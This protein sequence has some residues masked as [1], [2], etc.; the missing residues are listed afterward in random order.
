[1]Q[2]D[3]IYKIVPAH[4][5]RIA[6][7]AGQFTGSPVDIRDGFIHFS[8]AAQVRETAARHFGGVEDLL[9][10]TV[11]TATLDLLWEPSRGGDLF[12]HLY[13][14]LPVTAV[15]SSERLPLGPDGAHLFP[16]SV[17]R[18]A[19]VGG[20]NGYGQ[21]IGASLPGWVAPPI[22]TRDDFVGH[23]C[24]VSP[25]SPADTD[26]LFDAFALDA[27]DREWTYLPYGPFVDRATLA[28]WVEE[29]SVADDPLLFTVRSGETRIPT[30][31]AGYL[32][33]MPASGSIEVGHLRFSR[34]LRR[35][36]AATEA[37]YLMMRRAFDLGYRRYEWKCDVFNEPSRAAALR[38]GFSFEGI[39]RQATVYKGRTRDTAWYSVIDSEWPALRDVFETWLSPAN[40][41][42]EGRQQTRLSQLMSARTR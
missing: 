37:M 11:S 20:L 5:W 8:T 28:A 23:F 22:P 42:G 17:L 1:M 32:R 41:D 26:A 6:E 13:G 18:G 33:I 15:V 31:V 36:P 38:L 16:A 39:F 24:D 30:G 10:V 19:P 4:L 14:P 29:R 12:P 2:S 35:T 34:L 40:F 7:E 25:V 21:R 27:D 9:V 3:V